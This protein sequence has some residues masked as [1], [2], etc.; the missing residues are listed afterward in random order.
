[1]TK[2]IKI[3][4]TTDTLSSPQYPS[5][6]PVTPLTFTQSFSDESS[7]YQSKQ[8]KTTNPSQ[9]QNNQNKHDSISH[10][11]HNPSFL[12]NHHY[13]QISHIVHSFKTGPTIEIPPPTPQFPTT[14]HIQSIFNFPFVDQIEKGFGPKTMHK[15]NCF[16]HFLHLNPT[17]THTKPN[18][19]TCPYSFGHLTHTF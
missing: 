6:T 4:F 5:P 12:P 2:I 17:P 15:S 11:P 16:G 14:Q 9:Y 3:L 1:M 13:P 7:F 8:P 19:S 18:S 10:I